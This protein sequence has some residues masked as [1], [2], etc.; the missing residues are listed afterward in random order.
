MTGECAT[1][2]SPRLP[3]LRGTWLPS[4]LKHA[5]RISV[6]KM[7]RR[8]PPSFPRAPRGFTSGLPLTPRASSDGSALGVRPPPGGAISGPLELDRGGPL[9]GDDRCG[10]DPRPPPSDGDRRLGGAGKVLS[11]TMFGSP[12]FG[13]RS[14]PPPPRP[15]PPGG[16]RR[17]AALRWGESRASGDEGGPGTSCCIS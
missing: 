10:G 11:G 9:L 16:V 8:T 12:G 4:Y 7:Q 13:L 14:A 3:S 15:P 1:V 6:Y 17:R 5:L 2:L